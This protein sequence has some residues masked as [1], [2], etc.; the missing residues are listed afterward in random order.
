MKFT[1]TLAIQATRL[2]CTTI[3]Q[4]ASNLENTLDTL[5]SC[6]ELATQ[7]ELTSVITPTLSYSVKTSPPQNIAN[8]V[9]DKLI[10]NEIQQLKF[11]STLLEE[12]SPSKFMKL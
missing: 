7:R 11:T 10:E 4:R 3:K 1:E 5:L 8:D 6:K 12:L 9:L 2:L